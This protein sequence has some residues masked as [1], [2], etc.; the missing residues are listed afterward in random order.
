MNDGADVRAAL[1][2]PVDEGGADAGRAAVTVVGGARGVEC[3]SG[4]STQSSTGTARAESGADFE[5]VRTGVLLVRSIAEG[6]VRS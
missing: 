4:G 6:V 1:S 5:E 2:R 3:A